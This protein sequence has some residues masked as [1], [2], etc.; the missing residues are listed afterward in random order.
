MYLENTTDKNVVSNIILDDQ[1]TII[2]GYRQ[3]K[4]FAWMLLAFLS[5][6]GDQYS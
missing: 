1:S 3:H 6:L 2:F 4:E 5:S